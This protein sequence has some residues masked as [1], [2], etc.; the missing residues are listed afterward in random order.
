MNSNTLRKAIFHIIDDHK[1]KR[2]LNRLFHFILFSLIVLSSLNLLLETFDIIQKDYT[3]V[4]LF[5]EFVT[6]V[7]F[8]F[9]YIL[10]LYTCVEI[11]SYSHPLKGRLKYVITP[12]M[13]IDILALLPMY[14]FFL[15][16]YNSY[17]YVFGIFRV[18]RLFKAIR[19]LDAF[20][21]I[22]QVF[23]LKREQ[24]LISFTMIFFMF[25][26]Y[27]CL[28]FIA[29]NKAQPE[30]FKNITSAMWFTISSI[31]TVGYGDVIP[32]TPFGKIISGIIG[33]SGW[34]LFAIP[35]SILT[36]GFLKVTIQKDKLKC[37]NCGHIHD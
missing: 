12:L 15:S 32:I 4:L 7:F 13:L 17:F 23:Y 16:S 29:E 10:R 26:F 3:H 19:Y 30:V 5:L 1:S 9:E 33:I 34:L 8:T 25:I 31:T 22:G 20:R 14:Y 11:P 28:I 24:L 2:P 6:I 36:S 18:L 27:S 37:P 21:V 35:T